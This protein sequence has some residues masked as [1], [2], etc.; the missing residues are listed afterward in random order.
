MNLLLVF[1]LIFNASQPLLH[2]RGSASAVKAKNNVWQGFRGAGDSHTE[3]SRL[4]LEWSDTK[5]IAWNVQ[6]PGYGQSSPVVWQNKIFLTAIQ[7]ANKEKLLIACFDFFLAAHLSRPRVF[8]EQ[9]W[10]GVLS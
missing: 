1:L 3:A 8:R 4:P 10:R 6:L 5:N 7:G 9:G 2:S